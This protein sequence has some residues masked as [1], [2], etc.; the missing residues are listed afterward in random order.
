[1][2]GISTLTEAEIL[3]RR[4]KVALLKYFQ[5]GHTLAK[6]GAESDQFAPDFTRQ[7]LQDAARGLVAAKF[8]R[9]IRGKTRDSVY[10]TSE[11]GKT[12]LAALTGDDQV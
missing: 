5:A 4:L 8:L 12:T 6:L 7:E 9:R 10:I 3:G 1:M 11:D 2:K